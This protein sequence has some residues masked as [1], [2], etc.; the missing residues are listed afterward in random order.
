[1][2]QSWHFPGRQWAALCA[3]WSDMT[4]GA[5]FVAIPSGSG[6]LKSRETTRKLHA[7]LG[8]GSED[9]KSPGGGLLGFGGLS[10]GTS[11]GT[12]RRAAMVATCEVRRGPGY[13]DGEMIL[14]WLC[15]VGN[16]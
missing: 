5:G 11:A 8:G 13:D 15:S 16:V 4:W 6:R 12:R 3:G 10:G 1:M 14:T 9:G 2:L 7:G